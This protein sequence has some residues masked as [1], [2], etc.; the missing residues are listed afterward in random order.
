MVEGVGSEPA[1][2]L[3]PNTPTQHCRSEPV[4]GTSSLTVPPWRWGDNPGEDSLMRPDWRHRLVDWAG[5]RNWRRCDIR[6]A[7]PGRDGVRGLTV[8]QAR[9]VM[10][11]VGQRLVNAVKVISA[12]S[13]S[14]IQRCS[15]W[16]Q[17]ALG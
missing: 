3:L 7:A 11:S 17:I 16:S 13:A 4:W 10:C 12:T 5:N 1:K 2:V 8:H 9:A 15:S 14:E 6:S